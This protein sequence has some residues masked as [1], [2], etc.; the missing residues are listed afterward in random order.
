MTLQ[1]QIY[2]IESSL[3]DFLHQA[4]QSSTENHCGQ[5]L[6]EHLQTGGKRLRARLAL[7]VAES[8]GLSSDD[9]LPWACAVEMLHNATLIHDDIQDGDSFR[10][11]QPTTWKKHG[12]AQAINVGDLGLMLPFDIL[13]RLNCSMEHKWQLTQLISQ[14][15]IQTVQGQANEMMLLENRHLDRAHYFQCVTQKTGAFFSLPVHGSAI[16]AGLDPLEAQELAEAFLP[17]GILFQLQDDLLDCYG[18]K[19]REYKGND[20]REGKVSIL[21][22]NHLQ[23]HPEDYFRVMAILTA[24]REYL[25]QSTI[26]AMIESFHQSGAVQ[27]SIEDIQS[28]INHLQSP[29]LRKYPQVQQLAMHLCQKMIQPIAHLMGGLQ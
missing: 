3:E 2:D 27:A 5:L 12:V 18:N 16:L 22:V 21:V 13:N 23:L 10:R 25:T 6:L 4:T 20:L 28:Q 17:L 15:A 9:V 19:G 24:Q 14:S 7:T 1:S 11:G 29:I 26:N 8:L